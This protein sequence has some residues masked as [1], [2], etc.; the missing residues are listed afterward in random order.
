MPQQSHVLRG[1]ESHLGLLLRVSL[2]DSFVKLEDALVQL[3][4]V[5]PLLL[6]LVLDSLLLLI[7]SI[8]SLLEVVLLSILC[9]LSQT[10][11]HVLVNYSCMCS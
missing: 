6:D 10:G 1:L 4:Q 3:C 2:S 8:P 7:V 11:Q 9:E 5:L